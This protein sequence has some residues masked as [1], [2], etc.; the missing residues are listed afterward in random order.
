MTGERRDSGP[1]KKASTDDQIL[2]ASVEAIS[3]NRPGN[4]RASSRGSIT[5]YYSAPARRRKSGRWAPGYTGRCQHRQPSPGARS[6]LFSDLRGTVEGEERSRGRLH[7]HQR[8]LPMPWMSVQG[9]LPRCAIRLRRRLHG[10]W[11]REVRPT[12]A[13]VGGRTH[14]ATPTAGR[15]KGLT[16][17]AAAGLP[18]AGLLPH[19]PPAQR[20]HAHG[21]GRTHAP[22]NRAAHS[23]IQ[24]LLTWR[25]TCVTLMVLHFCY[26]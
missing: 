13:H 17:P 14:R 7:P 24:G 20:A 9:V 11:S 5:G 26:S 21:G 10:G 19:Q 12:A 2:A 1:I 22:H 15:L 18:D 8:A 6:G 23:P 16:K 25:T 4:T 3:R